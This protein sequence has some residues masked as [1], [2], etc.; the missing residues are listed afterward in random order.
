MSNAVCA[1]LFHRER[2]GEGQRIDCTLMGTALAMQTSQF[3]WLETFDNEVIPAMLEGLHEARLAKKSF[4]EQQKI[5]DGF[6][7]LAAGNIY[8]RVYQTA[9]GFVAVGALSFSLRLKVLAATGLKDPR[10]KPDGTFEM[11]P[12]GWETLGPKL[13]EEA[14]AL[15]LTKSTDEWIAVLEKHGVPAGPLFFV[16][17]LF[18]HPQTKE[19]G[20]VVELE[21][22][23]LGKMRMVGPPFQM[24]KSPLAAQGP[25]PM[26]GGD[27][28]EVLGEYGF[29][30]AEV[31][32]LRE[33][34]AL[35]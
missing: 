16:E 6:R 8:Y 33:S 3:M 20:L 23:L 21:H 22:P 1:A 17:E 4:V 27:A 10:F 5:H 14:E 34:G 15:F 32:A 30:S 24:S 25:S 7:P 2:T 11:M 26:L 9:D 35:R 19:N 12:A 18:D 28:D 29:S 31:Q 13:V